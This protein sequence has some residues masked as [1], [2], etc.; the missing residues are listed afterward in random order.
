MTSRYDQ[1]LAKKED[2]AE[3]CTIHRV[4][5]GRFDF[6]RYGLRKALDICKREHVD[7]VHATTFMAAIPA[8]ILKKFTGLPTVLHVHEIYGQLWYR[9]LGKLGH[10]SIVL[11]HI[12]FTRFR[13]DKYLCVSHYTKNNLR[14]VYGIDDKKLLTV[15]NAIDYDHW[16]PMSDNGELRKEYKLEGKNIVLFFGRP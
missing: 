5:H 10:L 11:E 7:I 16:K 6:M 12:I 4:G 13:F 2:Y 14:I 9:F 8:G 15:Y 3:N 1:S